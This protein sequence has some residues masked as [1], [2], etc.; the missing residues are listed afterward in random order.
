MT[1]NSLVLGKAPFNHSLFAAAVTS[2]LGKPSANTSIKTYLCFLW[3]IDEPMPFK[4]F[5]EACS[6]ISGW[7][8][9]FNI[10]TNGYVC[11]IARWRDTPHPDKYYL[12]VSF[13]FETEQY[14]N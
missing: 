3:E 5:G 4:R 8:E 1:R 12:R 14:Q 6:T 9:C 7:L 10:K 2:L 11:D 13:H